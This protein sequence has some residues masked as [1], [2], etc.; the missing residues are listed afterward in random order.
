MAVTIHRHEAGNSAGK[1]LVVLPLGISVRIAMKSLRVRF[2]RSL[3]TVISLILAISFHAYVKVNANVAAGVVRSR[4]AAA[5]KVIR[6]LGYDTEMTAGQEGQGGANPAQQWIL[7]LSLLVCVVG[8]V[9]TQLMA[10]TE[11]YRE[12]GTMKCLGALNR[13]IV[14]LF[15]IEAAVQGMSGAALG[16][17]CGALLSLAVWWI[18]LGPGWAG[19][20]DWGGLGISLAG[21]VLLGSAL[22]IAGVLYPALVAARMQPVEA[23]RGKE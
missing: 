2:L 4:D 16:A 5:V 17:V 10:V 6:H 18:R 11:R 14:R 13:F 12:I 23:M 20:V 15:L 3:I 21:S 9:N 7:F 22:S 19:F 1:R 8:I